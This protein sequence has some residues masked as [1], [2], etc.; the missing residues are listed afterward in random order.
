MKTN[1]S[2]QVFAEAWERGVPVADIMKT[3]RV[4]R[5]TLCHWRKE[6]GLASRMT[7]KSRKGS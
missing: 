4:S 6:L 1:L 3:L 7:Y 5:R 2:K